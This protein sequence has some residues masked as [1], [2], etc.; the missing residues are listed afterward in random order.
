[1][2]EQVKTNVKSLSILITRDGDHWSIRYISD[3]TFSIYE[4]FQ[5]L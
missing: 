2:N 3:D 5:K 1:M 4:L